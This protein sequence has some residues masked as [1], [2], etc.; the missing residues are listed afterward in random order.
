MAST[1][2][3]A[4][5]SAVDLGSLCALQPWLFTSDRL[6]DQAEAKRIC[7]SCPNRKPC[8]AK[9]IK[10]GE[11]WDIWGGMDPFERGLYRKLFGVPRADR[12]LESIPAA[13]L[14][15]HRRR[16]RAAIAKDADARA[17]SAA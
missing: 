6:A 7:L 4:L 10:A 3:G 17:E 16:I 5:P 13:L 15:P 9:A 12:N 11:P 14:E 1:E 2:P 8:L